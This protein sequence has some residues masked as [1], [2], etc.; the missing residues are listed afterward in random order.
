MR[1]RRTQR[2][3][4]HRHVTHTESDIATARQRETQAHTL[5]I[6]TQARSPRKDVHVCDVCGARG[7]GR[8]WV[9]R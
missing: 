2:H 6:H 5:K 1:H 3:V 4:T 8:T 7:G 9:F